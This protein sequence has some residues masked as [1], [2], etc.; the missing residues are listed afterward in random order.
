[1]VKLL[2]LRR[3][4][5]VFLSFCRQR[6]GIESLLISSHFILRKEAPNKKIWSA[7]R[8]SS[9]FLSDVLSTMDIYNLFGQ[10]KAP[11]PTLAQLCLLRKEKVLKWLLQIYSLLS[12]SQIFSRNPEPDI[13]S[14]FS[15][16]NWKN[17]IPPKINITA[18]PYPLIW[19][20]LID[21]NHFLWILIPISF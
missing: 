4:G 1:M 19:K 12:W 15:D 6:N 18:P 13:A 17:F 21:K 11:L 14:E 10:H 3:V 2:P 5:L 7:F 8:F 16:V 20:A 9:A